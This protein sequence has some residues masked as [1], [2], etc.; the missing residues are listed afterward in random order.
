MSK[1]K[2]RTKTMLNLALTGQ[3]SEVSEQTSIKNP[4]NLS[5]NASENN[6]HKVSFYFIGYDLPGF[7]LY[8]TTLIEAT[9][10]YF[11]HSLESIAQGTE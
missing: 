10:G 2:S 4:G 3:E 6:I 1:F 5:E 9:F 7:C 11:I 8:H